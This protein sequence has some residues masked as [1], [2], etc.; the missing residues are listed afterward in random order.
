M[1]RDAVKPFKLCRV[2][3]KNYCESGYCSECRTKDATRATI[4]VREVMDRKVVKTNTVSAMPMDRNSILEKY[5]NMQ[6]DK[7]LTDAERAEAHIIAKYMAI[8]IETADMAEK[9]VEGKISNFPTKLQDLC[10]DYG[11]ISGFDL[12][13]D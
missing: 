2:C 4:A 10:C 3:G 7:T 5:S 8:G 11:I 6:L 9:Y 12:V 13:D 1:D